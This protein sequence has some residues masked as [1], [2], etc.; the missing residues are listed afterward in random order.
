MAARQV[1]AATTPPH[2]ARHG[3]ATLKYADKYSAVADDDAASAKKREASFKFAIAEN[4]LNDDNFEEAFQVARE[5]LTLFREDGDPGVVDALRLMLKALELKSQMMHYV[6]SAEVDTTMEEAERLA[7]QELET[8][9]VNQDRRGEAVMLLSLGELN[10]EGRGKAKRAEAVKAAHAALKLLRDVDDW[11]EL[12]A[13]LL[14]LV[15]IHLGEEVAMEFGRE[16]LAVYTENEDRSGEAKSFHGI[17]MAQLALKEPDAG[18]RHAQ[19]ALGLFRDLGQ[20]KH[21]AYELYFIA[22]VFLSIGK[23]AEAL[24]MAEEAHAIF[25]EIGHSGWQAGALRPVIRSLVQ[26]NADEALRV[27]RQA[28]VSFKRGN[29]SRAFFIALDVLV[30]AHLESGKADL[31]ESLYAAEEALAIARELGMS[32][33]MACVLHNIARVQLARHEHGSALRA[34]RESGKLFMDLD[35]D[36]DLAIVR[37]TTFHVFYDMNDIE[38]ALQTARSVRELSQTLEDRDWEAV[39]CLQMSGAHHVRQEYEQAVRAALEAQAICKDE[40]NRIGEAVAWD[41][42]QQLHL[43]TKDRAEAVRACKMARFLYQQAGQ[44]SDEARMLHAISTW[45]SESGLF[46]EALRSAREALDIVRRLG[47]AKSEVAVLLLLAHVQMAQTSVAPVDR[48]I[49]SQENYYRLLDQ[50]C[51]AELVTRRM[52]GR[53]NSASLSERAAQSAQEAVAIARTEIDDAEYLAYSLY[54]LSQVH[55]CAGRP[56]ECVSDASEA[57]GLFKK[58]GDKRGEAN[59]LL[60]I[61]QGHHMDGAQEVAQARQALSLFT[62]TGDLDGEARAKEFIGHT[63]ALEPSTSFSLAPLTPVVD[64]GPAE[65]PV[66]VATK[67]FDVAATRSMIVE[68]ASEA[69]GEEDIDLD[70]PLMD[71]GLDSLASVNFRQRL[72]AESGLSMPASLV[73]DYPTVRALIDFM[74]SSQT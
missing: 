23:P 37:S 30:H 28:A 58:G 18:I 66:P 51:E 41:F 52:F 27:A 63:R 72:Q 49:V 16:A 15:N 1:G 70:T 67:N 20:K 14:L 11:K 17:A 39:A 6:N 32:R 19:E 22:D 21:E 8:F 69:T 62:E 73:F 56:M 40:G 65:D 33:W 44:R 68:L 64:S 29:D 48:N 54:V 12:C 43:E 55:L 47:D 45:Q 60:L 50:G 61:A 42:L 7:V 71:A 38:K 3:L 36:R 4:E 74:R 10:F 9:K 25:Q 34:L 31:E 5:V 24:P 57:L 59:A 53:D 2:Q 35:E 26:T 13:C 46:R